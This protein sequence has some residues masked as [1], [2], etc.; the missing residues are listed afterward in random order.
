V[1]YRFKAGKDG[2]HPYAGLTAVKGMLYGTTYQGG[3]KGSGTVFGVTTS[4]DEKVIY[5]FKGGS[6]G[7]YPY[8][9]LLDLNGALY[10]TTYQGGVSPGWGVIFKV[11]T[12]GKE[13]VLY[14]FRASSDGAHPYFAGLIVQNGSLYGTTYQGG[15]KGAGTIFEESPGGGVDRVIY[16][17]KAGTDGQYPYAGLIQ[18]NGTLFGTTEAGG[19][20]GAGTVFDFAF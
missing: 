4:G 11:S 7:Q 6:D 20:S 12:S 1:L 5:S 17:F 19:A 3:T 18:L 15:A 13:V 14:R 10:G 9:P 16:S 2:A 8:A